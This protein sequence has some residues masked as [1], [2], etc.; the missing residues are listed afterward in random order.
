MLYKHEWSREKPTKAQLV[1]LAAFPLVFSNVTKRG[2][3]WFES[4]TERSIFCKAAMRIRLFRRAYD[5]MSSITSALGFFFF[6]ILPH[7]KIAQR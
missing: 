1:Q 6:G 2:R 7:A 3:P 5:Y 4:L